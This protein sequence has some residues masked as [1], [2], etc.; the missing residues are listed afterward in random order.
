VRDEEKDRKSSKQY[1][2][3]QKL[4]SVRALLYMVMAIYIEE[5]IEYGGD[6]Y[7]II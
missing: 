4:G 6:S 7:R 3:V 5:K 2:M 1:R